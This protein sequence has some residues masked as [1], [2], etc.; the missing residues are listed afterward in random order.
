[1]SQKHTDQ[2]KTAALAS[3]RKLMPGLSS[4]AQHEWADRAADAMAAGY[5]LRPDAG[6]R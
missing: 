4:G 3:V 5:P 6:R 2:Q 1:M